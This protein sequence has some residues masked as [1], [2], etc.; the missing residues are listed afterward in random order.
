MPGR[1]EADRGRRPCRCSARLG[2]S[3]TATI[4]SPV[5]QGLLA[6]AL[7]D[8]LSGVQK[9]PRLRGELRRLGIGALRKAVSRRAGCRQ[10]Q[11]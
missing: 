9:G 10:Q 4:R 11:K 7:T 5:A 8:T 3:L 2:T 6:R 1:F